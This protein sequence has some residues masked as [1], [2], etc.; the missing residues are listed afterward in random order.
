MTNYQEDIAL[1]EKY[2][3][4]HDRFIVMLYQFQSVWDRHIRSVRAGKP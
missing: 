4:K 2:P 3:G 1:Q